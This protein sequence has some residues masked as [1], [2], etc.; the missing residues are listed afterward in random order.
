MMMI[1]IEWWSRFSDD[2]P[3]LVM[4]S[5]DDPDRIWSRYSDDDPDRVIIQIQWWWSK[6]SDD[7]YL[8]EDDLKMKVTRWSSW[9]REEDHYW[10]IVSRE[11][12]PS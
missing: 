9:Y 11:Y 5:I 10:Q 2:D 4:M 7:P 3:D 8:D 6:S 1:Q 12:L